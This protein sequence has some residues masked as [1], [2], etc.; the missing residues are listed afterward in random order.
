MAFLRKG[1][2]QEFRFNLSA[3]SRYSKQVD[4]R[5]PVELKYN[6]WF[7]VEILFENFDRSR[8]SVAVDN[9]PVLYNEVFGQIPS[10]PN[11]FT[12]RLGIYR[13]GNDQPGNMNKVSEIAYKNLSF[14]IYQR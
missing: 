1:G 11:D 4:K 3:G 6:E 2:Y 10:C 9:L 8:L 13:A 7:D 5:S 12:L 14:E